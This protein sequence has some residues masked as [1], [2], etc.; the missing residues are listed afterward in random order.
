LINLTERVRAGH[1]RER[2]KA[3]HSRTKHVEERAVDTML[4]SSDAEVLSVTRLEE[5]STTSPIMAVNGPRASETYLHLVLAER[6]DGDNPVNGVLFLRYMR[7]MLRYAWREV[8]D[9]V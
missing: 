2:A 3:T 9:Y 1:A 6:L 5:V 8:I 7:N 4:D